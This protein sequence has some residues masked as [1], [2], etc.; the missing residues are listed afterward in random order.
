MD[1]QLKTSAALSPW[2]YRSMRKVNETV[3]FVLIDSQLSD[4]ELKSVEEFSFKQFQMSSAR[5]M[6][7]VVLGVNCLKFF[8]SK[9][10]KKIV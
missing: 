1:S 7:G 9:A 2:T 5:H 3:D 8:P 10:I 4:I 6:I